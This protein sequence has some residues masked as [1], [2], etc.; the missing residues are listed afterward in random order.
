M[1]IKRLFLLFCAAVIGFASC[2]NNDN[3][4]SPVVSTS[5]NVTNAS[6]DTLNYFINGTRQNTTA[7]LVPTST[8]YYFSIPAGA[9]TLQIKQYGKAPYLFTMP[10]NY[11][12]GEY[13]TL[14]ITGEALNKTF[15]TKDSLTLDTP[16]ARV[17]FVHA[18][19]DAGTLNIAI[20]DTVSFTN[21]EYTSATLF[22]SLVAG[23]KRVRV[24]L[25]GSTTAKVDTTITVVSNSGYTIYTKG[26]L[27]GTGAS[28]LGI[29]VTLNF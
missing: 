2:K 8:S 20:G 13:H 29:G 15:I 7:G 16:N 21:R 12:K 27:N 26:L 17:R 23:Q 6:A 1:N 22:T 14:F 9:L 19:P 18:A 28:K 11:S 10:L 24:Y 5:L 3:V 4:F 25:Q